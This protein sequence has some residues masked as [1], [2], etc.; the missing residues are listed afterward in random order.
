MINDLTLDRVV[1]D[2]EHFTDLNMINELIFFDTGE[3]NEE[4]NYNMGVLE[5]KTSKWYLNGNLMHTG[6]YKNGLKDGNWESYLKNGLIY[7]KGLMIEGRKKAPFNFTSYYGDSSKIKFFSKV[8]DESI[9]ITTFLDYYLMYFDING[10]LIYEKNY[11]N[12]QLDGKA[13]WYKF[14]QKSF[15]G[16]YKKGL[17]DGDWT[18]WSKKG[19]ITKTEIFLDGIRIGLTKYKY[20]FF[21][22][23]IKTEK[24]YY[25]G[26]CISGC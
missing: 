1:N 26:N 18:Y 12:D 24:K 20:G 25:E 19:Q 8:Y 22:D 16:Y 6:L 9:N 10:E 3:L 2:V 23:Q 15:S 21:D 4:K 14:G 5:G 17:A 11:I 13:T 7:S